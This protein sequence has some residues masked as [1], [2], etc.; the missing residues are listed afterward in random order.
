MS[1]VSDSVPIWFTL[2]RIAFATPRVD[3]QP[4]ALD[5]RHEQVVADQLAAVADRVA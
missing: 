4:Q 5:V 3:A 2:T 1:S